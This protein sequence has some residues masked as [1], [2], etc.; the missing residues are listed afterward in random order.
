MITATRLDAFRQ[1]IER[2][3]LTPPAT[4]LADGELHRFASNGDRADD[5]GWYI[6]FPDEIPAGVFGCWRNNIKKTWS[7]KAD[8][9][10]T[11][12]ERERH[13]TRFDEARRQR[14]QD[15]RL[16]HA[17]AAQKAQA[18]W[19]Q[20]APATDQYSYLQKKG[21]G[22]HGLRVVRV[23]NRDL[24]I[25]PVTIDGTMTSLQFIFSDGAKRFLR[26]GATKGG[27]YT[28]GDL[29]KATTLLICEGFAT[30]A[31][32]YEATGY[33]T[34]MTFSAGNLTPVAKQLRQLCPAVTLVVCG[35]NDLSGTGQREARQAAEA[36]SGRLVFPET[37]G[38]DFN[39]IHVQHGLDAVKKAIEAARTREEERPTM[40]TATADTPG[41]SF[42]AYR[43]G[44]LPETSFRPVRASDLLAEVQ[45]PTTWLLEDYL[46]MGSLALLAGKPKEGKTTLVYELAVRV[47]QGL[48]FLGRTT[49]QG[50]VLILAVEEHRRDV[51][52]RLQNLG[53]EG[54]D[55]LYIHVGALSPTPTFFAH[56][57]TFIHDHAIR[58]V[59]VDTL[60]AFWHV[61]N[62]NDASEMTKAVKPLLHLARE[63]DACML[64]IHH[65]RKSEGSHGDEIRGSGALFGL[66][67]IAI[68][69][70]RHS[71]ETQRLLQA[72]S[73]YPETPSELVVDLREH[74]YESLG[75]PAKVGKADKL[76]RLREALT[77]QPEEITTLAKH[78]GVS[79]RDATRLLSL[80]LENGETIREGKGKRNDPHRFRR[81]VSGNPPISKDASKQETLDSFLA[82]PGAS[83]PPARN[84]TR[85]DEVIDEA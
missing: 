70:K 17:E 66:V 30:G 51:M 53:A 9:T 60:A 64:L 24:L 6:Y 78:A 2:A 12:A 25:V 50:S 58:L 65:A 80:L 45:E 77:E 18:I 69:M 57:S 83:V 68:V 20:A 40:T 82:T 44:G 56:L 63:S 84:E 55:D 21:I 67:D 28:I 36:V 15:E 59:L 61:Q 47:A 35:D 33:P 4:I 79:R 19:D 42:L 48:P 39:D 74:G 81:F 1:E 26:N 37:V 34:V 46:P 22:P 85:D 49:R 14:E 72:Q 8:S 54:L 31:S 7:G 75:D 41:N 13:R 73:R 62:E 23:D 11:A 71:V 76:R 43:P 29:T 5:A 10:L 52:S 32:L 16:R 27:S 3:G 38:M